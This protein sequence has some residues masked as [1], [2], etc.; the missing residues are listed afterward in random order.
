MSGLVSVV[1]L[2][3]PIV[4]GA[5]VL[6]SACEKSNDV[7]DTEVI[8][9]RPA[10]DHR[11]MAGLLFNGSETTA[12]G[13]AF[14]TP[15]VVVTAAH[16]ISDGETIQVRPGSGEG[17]ALELDVLAT[18]VHPQFNSATMQNDVAILLVE[19]APA[20]ANII[21]IPLNRSATFPRNETSSLVTVIGRGNVSS[22][23]SYFDEVLRQVDV[24]VVPTA[25]CADSYD[26]QRITS[27][28]ICAGR[29]VTGGQDS[30]QGDSGGP[31]VA[32]ANGQL[33]LVGIVS[34]G[35][36][37][38][39]VDNPGVYTRV[40]SVAPWIEE[41][42]SLLTTPVTELDERVLD[43]FVP[44]FCDRSLKST[45]QLS[46]GG[47]GARGSIEYS[48]APS[49]PFAP[50]AAAPGNGPVSK[51]MMSIPGI[52]GEVKVELRK[53]PQA[54]LHV[55]RSQ[56]HWNVPA[57][58]RVRSIVLEC[59]AND[60]QALFEPS[61]MIAIARGNTTYMVEKEWRDGVRSNATITSCTV[62]HLKAELIS[63]THGS[64]TVDLAR[65]SGAEF[66]V[67]G[68]VFQLADL[69]GDTSTRG[70]SIEVTMGHGENAEN[71]FALSNGS[72]TDI[73][74]WKVVCNFHFTLRDAD[75]TSYA[76][77]Q[78][79]SGRWGV[80]FEAPASAHGTIVRGAEKSF[81]LT[82][83][84]Q[85]PGSPSCSINEVP[86]PVRVNR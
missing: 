34:W 41:Q 16:C 5:L 8:G 24:P 35:E 45:K 29:A 7:S 60:M 73:F 25:T 42:I 58:T 85:M 81:A 10:D 61:G 43:A 51:C 38:A 63:Q 66:G 4:L 65:F 27:G 57:A 9:G 56:T 6:M 69:D 75:G 79:R 44:T 59:D 20:N 74:T 36:G 80:G 23:G 46:G 17:D 39:Q 70:V 55:S 53:Q 40:S 12:C 50:V 28:V 54:N 11:F 77:T 19:S 15:R 22:F 76:T 33:H 2:S 26:S 68:K 31:L 82:V 18:I 83:Q 37:C 14:V 62:G 84:G 49:G 72:T 30:C 13:G 86:V 1:R 21:P 3:R 48:H 71:V 47:S 52:Q 64:T 67:E 32:A 78:P